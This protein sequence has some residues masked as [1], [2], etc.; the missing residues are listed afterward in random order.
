M[1]E[2]HTGSQRLVGTY[3]VCRD[4]TLS[5]RCCDKSKRHCEHSFDFVRKPVLVLALVRRKILI[6]SLSSYGRKFHLRPRPRPETSL[7][8]PRIAEFC[9]KSLKNVLNNAWWT[10]VNLVLFVPTHNLVL[11]RSK[12]SN[13]SSSHQH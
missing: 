12:F 5:S 10:R 1:H 3:F 2:T 8:W 7:I 6:S 11:V 4:G 13:T 9:R